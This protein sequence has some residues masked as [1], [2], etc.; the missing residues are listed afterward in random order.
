MAFVKGIGAFVE[1]K[2]K[3]SGWVDYKLPNPKTGK[4]EPKTTYVEN[5]DGWVIGCGVYK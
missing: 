3:G 1:T 5:L 2:A 4:I